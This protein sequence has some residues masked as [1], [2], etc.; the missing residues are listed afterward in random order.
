MRPLLA[1]VAVA[2]LA[3]VAAGARAGDGDL[4]PQE[5]KTLRAWIED[6]GHREA[7][8]REAAMDA[9]RG[10]GARALPLLREARE[11]RSEELRARARLLV[12]TLEAAEASP[13][14]DAADWFTLKGDM[15]RTGAR[16]AAPARVEIR[17]V[18]ELGARGDRPPLDA[19]LAASGDLVLAVRDDRLTAL[20]AGDLAHR[21]EVSLGSPII[22][23][24][25]AAGGR[26][27]VGTARGLTAIDL[28]TRR[29]V[30]TV[31][32][33]YGVGAAPLAAGNTLYACLGMEGVVAVDPENGS[34]RWVHR[35]AAGR[36]APVV[37]GGRVI[38]GT[39]AGEVLGLDPAT[40]VRRWALTVD[41]RMAFAPAALGS[42]VIVGDGGRRLRCIDAETGR[43]L[44]TRSVEGDF[45]GDGPA[46]S[47]VAVVV[48]T[49]RH[50][51]EAYDP[52][53]GRRL[54]RRWVGTLHISSPVLA[55]S[56]VLFGAR[57]RLV[58]VLAE[59]GDDLW[60]IDL[61]GEVACPLVSGG[62]AYAVA[63]GRV[64]ALR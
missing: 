58:A 24:P 40:G 63:G 42:S 13:T 41:G 61:D 62:T 4:T 43:V 15:G 64:V 44:W 17:A 20:Q 12:Q 16:G 29:E 50:E 33:A 27:Y 18:R 11:G 31:A 49:T 9:L 54:W 52:A 10:F 39:E 34:R 23:S 21:W 32:A 37:A 45:H 19:P 2:L 3:L 51:V 53:S 22:S 48:S 56:V 47:P 26:V 59:S 35:C 5:T 55:G 57:T 25:V 60:E 36:S 6:L 14:A 38:V 7:P 8:R 30:W 1:A 28:E 46:V